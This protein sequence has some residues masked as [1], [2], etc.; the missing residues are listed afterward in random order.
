M[1]R[2][3]LI[4]NVYN[5]TGEYRKGSDLCYVDYLLRAPLSSNESFE[6]EVNY[7]SIVDNLPVTADEIARETSRCAILSKV[8][9]FVKFG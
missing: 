6:M 9:D 1:H 3:K 5:Y 7:F 8:R 4:L 2:W